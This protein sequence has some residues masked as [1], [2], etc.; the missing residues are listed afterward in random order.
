MSKRSGFT[1]VE[2][3]VVISIIG[4]LVALLLPAVQAARETARKAQCSTQLRELGQAA[5]SYE[6]SKK[7]FPGWQDVVARNSGLPLDASTPGAS[8]T[9]NKVAGW[10]VLLMP[11]MDDRPTF[12]L[13]DDP[14]VALNDPRLTKFKP[15]L[16]CPSRETRFRDDAYTSY[17]ANAGFLPTGADPPV[18]ANIATSG[19]VVPTAGTDYWDVHQG[20]N[21]VFVDRVPVP[22]A[23][24]K[25][26][27]LA[28]KRLPRVTM[29]DI[30]DG[31]TNTLL[32]TENLM[33]GLWG[34]GDPRGYGTKRQLS[35]T[36]VWLYATEG[37]VTGT[38][39]G[40]TPTAVVT[41]DMKINGNNK[42]NREPNGITAKTCRPSAW[43]NGGVNVVFADKHTTFLTQQIDYDVYQQLMT[44]DSKKSNMYVKGYVLRATDIGQ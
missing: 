4:I 3:L 38:T 27:A 5:I 33:A 26:T 10:P 6:S 25:L 32:F 41:A 35:M 13:W 19:K 34:A 16:A 23:A 43:H 37:N 2:L 22:S 40:P 30:N 9:S 15:V 21:G 20:A 1:L 8:G 17:V 39:S 42:Q 11:Y 29:T 7:Y 36:F 24:T 31:L 44:A 28:P 14:T 12:D 18:Y